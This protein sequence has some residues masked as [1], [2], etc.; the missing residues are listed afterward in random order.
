ML[1]AAFVVW[2]SNRPDN[3]LLPMRIV[4]NRNRGG[5]YLAFLLATLVMFTVFLFLT[6]YFQGVLGYSALKAGVAFLPFP[7]GVIVSSVIASRTLPIFGPGCLARPASC[8]AALG[9]LWLTQLSADSSYL[10]HIV[11]SELLISLGMGQ[12]FVPLS[13]TA[14]LGVPN[15]DAGVAS[16]LVNTMQQVGGSLGIAFLNT[17]ATSAT[18]HYALG[19]GGPSKA[20]V[21]HGFTTAFAVGVGVLVLAAIIVADADPVQPQARGTG[22]VDKPSG[23]V[24]DDYG[25]PDAAGRSP[26]S[27]SV[28]VA[29][30]R[31][32][33]CRPA[34]AG[35]GRPP[36]GGR[37][38]PRR[39]EA[40]TGE[41][42]TPSAPASRTRILAHHEC[43]RREASRDRRPGHHRGGQ[44]LRARLR[45]NS[46]RTP[47]ASPPPTPVSRCTTST[48]CWSP[49]G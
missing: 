16:A 38:V 13:S 1:L 26:P 47:Y 14:L 9:V 32:T 21:T 33:D 19:H 2:E 18:A 36:P 6:Y 48:V 44:G 30:R 25:Y 27:P 24:S 37:P 20:A 12:V 10:T 34:Q 29:V 28:A 3:P 7:L 41:R 23:G 11:P 31:L 49:P 17:I 46:R 43:P 5:S 35:T 22:R 45:S 4:L 39:S 42:A 40:A 15:H 8:S